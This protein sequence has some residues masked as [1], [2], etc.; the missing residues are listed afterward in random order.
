M[1]KLK[2]KKMLNNVGW[3]EVT[4]ALNRVTIKCNEESK[5]AIMYTSDITGREQ[6]LKIL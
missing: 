3:Y 4:Y 1:L 2:K 5:N 6:N